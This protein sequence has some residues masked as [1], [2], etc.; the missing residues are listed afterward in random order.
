MTVNQLRAWR[1]SL[2][3]SQRAAAEALGVPKRT[4]QQWEQP[5]GKPHPLLDIAC[6]VVAERERA[7]FGRLDG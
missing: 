3:L 4:Y 7:K 5:H 6:P 2:R 1:E